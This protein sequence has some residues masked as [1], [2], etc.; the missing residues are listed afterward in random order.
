MMSNINDPSPTGTP[1]SP[2]LLSPPT[3]IG[4]LFSDKSEVIESVLLT[5]KELLELL[6]TDWVLS[7]KYQLIE[8]RCFSNL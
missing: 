5:K 6:V 7:E 2:G 1:G 8:Y 4:E 3:I